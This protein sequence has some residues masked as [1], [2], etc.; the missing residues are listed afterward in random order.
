[1]EP[2]LG[3]TFPSGWKTKL[4]GQLMSSDGCPGMSLTTQGCALESGQRWWCGGGG[5]GPAKEGPWPGDQDS[6]FQSWLRHQPHHPPLCLSFALWA[7]TV[8]SP[9]LKAREEPSSSGSRLASG[10]CPAGGARP[11]PP[12]R[13]SQLSPWAEATGSLHSPQNLSAGEETQP[14]PG[15]HITNKRPE[16]EP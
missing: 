14:L 11:T 4:Q 7:L 2:L 10:K 6:W 3:H 15:N 13:C 8:L 12:V 5:G 1:M 16:L 9:A